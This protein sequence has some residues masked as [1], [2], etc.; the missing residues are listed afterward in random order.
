MAIIGLRVVSNKQLAQNEEARYTAQRQTQQESMFLRGLAGH[1]EKAWQAAQQAKR[2]IEDQMLRSLRQRTGVYEPSDLALIRQQGGSEIYMMLTSAKCRGAEAWLREILLN[3][4]ERPWGLDPSPMPDLPPMVQQAIV[5]NV[6]MEAMAAGWEVDDSRLDERLLTVKTLAYKRMMGLARKIAERH[7][8][9][10][11]DQFADGGW[12]EALDEFIYDLV[13]FPNAFIKGP[14]MRKRKMRKW[15]PGQGGQ[16]NAVVEE[17][18]MPTYERRSPFDIFPSP[19]MRHIQFGNLIDRHQFTRLHLQQ[20]FGVP[21][22]S[23]DAMAQVLTEYGDKGYNSRQMNDHERAVLEL[24]RQE[25]YDPEGTMEALNFWGSCQ[26]HLLMQWQYENQVEREEE[27]LPNREY[28]IEAWK[29]GRYIIKAEVNPDPLGKKPYSKASFDSIAGAFWG[30]G[31]PEIIKDTAAMCNAAARAISNNAAVASGPQTEINVDRLADGEP[32]TKI[33]PW[34]IHQTVSDMT[35]NNQP[36]VRF[37]Q[38]QMH[39]QELLLIYNHFERVADNESGF[40]NYTYGDAKV[41]GAGRTSSGLAQLMGNVGKGVR[42]VVSQVDMYVIEQCVARQYDYNMEYHPDPSIK[43]DLRPV[44]RGSVAM[45]IKDQIALRQKEM[46]QATLNPLDAQIIGAR[47]RMEMLRPALKAAEFPVERI[48]PTELELELA[49]ATMPP[50]AQLLGKTGPNAAGEP[51]A[52]PGR[53]EG[54][55]TPEGPENQ[56]LA[57]NPPQ[58]VREREATQGY[59][60]GGMVMDRMDVNRPIKPRRYKMWRGDDGEMMAEEL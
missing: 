18:I 5:N 46:L 11:A 23:D 53:G 26:G 47:G 59:R 29:I 25:E 6:F 58:G 20:L 19:A 39:V 10:I 13:T 41:G 34:K 40:P 51:G 42:R 4:L 35:G 7:E 16:W 22:Y 49:M 38:P 2:S 48:L 27:I 60:D 24:R 50:P 17:V 14:V 45:L 52:A 30:Q 44:A 8:L 3:E 36:A 37:S 1:I 56:D 31:L 33:Y 28:Q 57:G 9:V 21:G 32:V 43:F 55:G 12:R 15:R 54:G